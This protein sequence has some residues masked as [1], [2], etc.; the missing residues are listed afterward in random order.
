MPQ[1]RLIQPF[2]FQAKLIWCDGLFRLQ[3]KLQSTYIWYKTDDVFLT[4]VFVVGTRF[5]SPVFTCFAV[6]TAT[7]LFT[8]LRGTYLVTLAV[9]SPFFPMVPRVAITAAMVTSIIAGMMPF[10]VF[11][12]MLPSFVVTRPMSSF[13]TVPGSSILAVSRASSLLQDRAGTHTAG[14]S[15]S[16]G[17][18][19]QNGYLSA[20]TRR[21]QNIKS[22]H[23]YKDNGW[24]DSCLVWKPI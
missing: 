7:P 8:V 1:S 4:I 10:F 2:Q 24:K 5:V 17:I 22:D 18:P 11:T 14:I 21:Q 9:P 13:F 6:L 16:A 15:A 19:V 12:G 20:G 3:F 23:R